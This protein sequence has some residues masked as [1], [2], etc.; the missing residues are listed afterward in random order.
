MNALSLQIQTKEYFLRDKPQ[1]LEIAEKS[2]SGQKSE[3]ESEV[4]EEQ[5]LVRNE[6]KKGRKRH[7]VQEELSV[8]KVTK[9]QQQGSTL[10]EIVTNV[11]TNM[12]Q[13]TNKSQKHSLPKK[14]MGRGSASPIVLSSE[15]EDTDMGDLGDLEI[16]EEERYKQEQYLKL[17]KENQKQ[18]QS[19]SKSVGTKQKQLPLVATDPSVQE[20]QKQPAVVITKPSVQEKQKQSVTNKTNVSKSVGAKQLVSKSKVK[21]ELAVIKENTRKTWFNPDRFDTSRIKHPKKVKKE[22]LDDAEIFCVKCNEVFE[23]SDDLVTH[24]KNCFKGRQYACTFKG[25]CNCTFSQKSLMHQHLK[26][27]HYDNPFKCE[28]CTQTFMYKKSLDSHLNQQHQQKEKDEF[29]YRCS[30]CDKATDDLT[31][32]K[33]HM[34]RHH[35]ALQM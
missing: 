21:S 2:E 14:W 27:V 6:L 30:E 12:Q 13:S 5:S 7:T 25:G 1:K 33:V 28:F 23:T 10:L 29:K 18:E 15:S 26:V 24:E 35:K 17:E 4:G 9:T 22:L 3:K 32:F 16:Q 11:T 34:N 8:P 20:K 31:E 19:V